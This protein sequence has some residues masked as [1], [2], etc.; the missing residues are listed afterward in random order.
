M[1]QAAILA[2][3]ASSGVSTGF[4]NRII[5]GAMLVDQRNSGSSVTPTAALHT[6]DRWQATCAQS[7]KFSVQQVSDA[8]DGFTKSLKVTSL[9]AYTVGSGETF[10]MRQVI[11]GQNIA[12]LAY[13]TSSTKPVT[14][15]FWVKSSLTGSFGVV[16][17]NGNVGRTYGNSYTINQANTWEYKSVTVPGDSVAFP[18]DNS[19]GLYLIFGLGVSSTVSAAAGSWQGSFYYGVTGATSVVSTNAATWQVTGVQFEVGNT[20]TNFEY[21]DYGNELRMCQRYFFQMLCDGTTM[22][23]TSATAY[24]SSVCYNNTQ[25]TFPVTM[26][27][28][29]T[30]TTSGQIYLSDGLGSSYASTINWNT[31]VWGITPQAANATGLTTGRTYYTT[32]GTAGSYVRAS[33]EL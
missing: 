3:S 5:N 19:Q 14:I 8:P 9:S 26:R 24:S 17:G 10:T 18:T 27:T 6:L 20:A 4:K 13:G 32:L 29:P 21:R 1:T 11:E 30:V 31:Y 12:D 15:S 23:L 22:P 2:S 16:L 25:I 33:S 28:T 7:S